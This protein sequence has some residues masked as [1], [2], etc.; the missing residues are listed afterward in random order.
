MQQ[1]FS[2]RLE[3]ALKDCKFQPRPNIR[4]TAEF[5]DTLASNQDE[6]SPAPPPIEVSP[7]TARP[8]PK[9][10]QRSR[11]RQFSEVL[12]ARNRP[13]DQQIELRKKRYKITNKSVPESVPNGPLKA[14][15][16]AT[17]NKS[18]TRSCTGG[19][20][21][22]QEDTV[23]AP[24]GRL[25]QERQAQS[26]VDFENLTQHQLQSVMSSDKVISLL[27]MTVGIVMSIVS[28]NHTGAHKDLVT[29]VKAALRVAFADEQGLEQPKQRGLQRTDRYHDMDTSQ[30]KEDNMYDEDV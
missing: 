2:A 16:S 12:A 29:E 20:V 18:K 25:R 24:P 11:V 14:T 13:E 7:K 1:K 5:P 10:V 23:P 3:L 19:Y 17:H 21:T 4:S 6:R 26:Q 9:K 15:V 27:V 30:E 28:A 22:E 8:L